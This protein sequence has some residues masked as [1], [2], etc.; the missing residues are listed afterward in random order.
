MRR[1]PVPADGLDYSRDSRCR[2]GGRGGD[3]AAGGYTGP[4]RDA[5]SRPRVGGAVLAAPDRAAAGL[6]ARIAELRTRL[7]ALGRAVVCFSGGVDSGYLLA[8]AA[9]VLGDGATALTAVSPS[10]APEER[11]GAERLARRIGVRQVLVETH[12]L[13]DARYASNPVNRCYFCK[14]EVYS[15]AVAEAARLGAAHVLDGFNADD[16]GDHR[17]GR[18]AAREQGVRSPLDETGFGKADVREAARRLGL[19]VWDKPALACL[20]SRFPYG[21]A[22]TPAR[23]ARVAAAERALRELGFRVCRVRFHGAAARI[24]VEPHEIPRLRS[25]GVRAEVVRRFRGAGFSRVTVDPRGYR[26][27]SLNEG[28][29]AA[30]REPAGGGAA[31]AGGALD[32]ALREPAGS[33]SR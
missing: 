16:R 25:A 10:L 21:A 20:S 31:G 23:L 13:D 19:P 33:T 26:Q 27:G 14:H 9:G 15:V 2:R 28:L 30:G 3:F 6:D 18:R 1:G 7:A 17:P 8:E 11:D 12:E 22:I 29:S 32:E 24:E 4:M 5:D